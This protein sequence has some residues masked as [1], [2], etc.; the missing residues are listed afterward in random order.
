MLLAATT[1]LHSAGAVESADVDD[2]ANPQDASNQ[3][4]QCGLYLAM[5]STSTPDEPKWGL[6]AGETFQKGVSIGY[7]DVAIQTFNLLGNSLVDDSEKEEQEEE[8]NEESN[9]DDDLSTV[10]EFFEQ[11]IW[12]PQSSGGQFELTA[13]DGRTVTAIPGAGV[14]GA[15]NPKLTNVD[16]NHSS[17]YYRPYWNEY[18]GMSHVGRGAYS[19]FYNVGMRTTEY[20]PAGMEIFI[21]YGDNWEDENDEEEE[22]GQSSKITKDDHAKID[23]TIDKMIEFFEKHKA[24]LNDES[25]ADIYQFLIKD[26]MSAAAGPRKGAKITKLLPSTP[27]ELADIKAAG[28]ILSVTEPSAVRRLDWLQQ[29]GRCM[30]N[31][32]SGPS[33]I[34]YAGRGAFATRFIPKGGL[35]SP[36]PLVQIPNERIMDMHPIKKVEDAE[37]G[38]EYFVKASNEVIG[39]QLLLNYCYGHPESTMLFFPSGAITGLIN[40]GPT[41]KNPKQGQKQANAKMRWSNHPNNHKQW[42]DISPD[43]MLAEGNQHLGLL[44]EIVAL[45]D[46]EEGE[47]ILIDYGKEWEDAW[48]EHVESWN[49]GIKAG[50]IPK[51]WSLKGL[52]VMDQ[53]KN[54]PYPIAGDSKDEAL[55]D[56]VSLQCFLMVKKPPPNEPHVTATGDK[57][58]YWAKPEDAAKKDDEISNDELD[59][60]VASSLVYDAENLFECTITERQ[61]VGNSW[62]YTVAWNRKNGDEEEN[63]NDETMETAA[64]KKVQT[65]V[66]KVP[67]SAFVVMDK[68]GTGDQFIPEGF[69]HYIGIPDDVF[70]KGP[71]RDVTSTE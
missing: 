71:W 5:S 40:H 11:Y 59:S 58:R 18:A 1:S 8:E 34:P 55:P 52:D 39:S 66:Q 38:E 9:V 63:N 10:V 22:E 2:V 65:I 25:K 31:I 23:E 62:E 4:Q 57:I 54:K 41:S 16:W 36:V 45:R 64:V 29:Y 43:E 46:I 14:L 50:S 17:S 56:N 37:D 42:F 70:P 69:R 44:M 28:G 24:D 61:Q 33:T 20:I 21:N 49:A 35:V 7:G 13:N 12:V 60:A 6:Y 32:K 3:Q 27:E 53:Y 47:E 26:V 19:N 68:P 48:S 67:H 30:D 15:Y 51:T